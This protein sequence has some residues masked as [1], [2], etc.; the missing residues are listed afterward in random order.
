M[1][2]RFAA[3]ALALALLAAGCDSSANDAGG[4]TGDAL[5]PP[6][7]A[8]ETGDPCSGAPNPG[9]RTVEF[10]EQQPPA[11]GVDPPAAGAGRRALPLVVAFHFAGG[12]GREMEAAVGLS[13]LADREGF[14]VLYPNAVSPSHFWALTPRDSGDDL[15]ITYNLIRHVETTVCI[16]DERIYATGVSNGGGMAARAGCELSDVVAAVAPVAGGYRG[17][18]PCRPERP[19]SVLEI[20]G[21]ADTVVPYNGRGPDHAGSVPAYLAGWAARDGCRVGPARK[22]RA[23]GVTQLD[24][25]KCDQGVAVRHLRLPGTTHGWPG[26]ESGLP[27][28]DPTGIST[29]R[30]V[31]RFFKGKTL[32]DPF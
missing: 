27:R 18:K 6:Q 10:P 25:G 2:A 13:A 28:R 14:A 9:S 21:T 15:A 7:A 31:W 12:T 5:G 8:R 22:A 1:K 30:E 16:D 19:E 26:S 24:W 17:L 23:R 20:H 11:H 4:P 3:V 32:S 29:D